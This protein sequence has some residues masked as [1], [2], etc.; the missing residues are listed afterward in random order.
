MA[1]SKPTGTDPVYTPGTDP[2]YTPGTARGAKL[3]ALLVDEGTALVRNI[4]ED[5]VKNMNPPSLREQLEN[6]RGCL[7]DNAMFKRQGKKCKVNLNR[8]QRD[9]LYPPGCD[10]PD[11]AQGFDI[12]LLERLLND[13][14]WLELGR[15]APHADHRNSFRQFRNNNYG[16]ISSTDLSQGDF[17]RLWKELSEILVAL[18]GDKDKISE[19]YNRS[20][21]PELE[22]E[23]FD[24]LEKLYKDDMELKAIVLAQGE[25]LRKRQEDIL[26][27]LRNLPEKVRDAQSP[28]TDPRQREDSSSRAD[29]GLA[30][31][32]HDVI[33]CLKDLYATE[34]AHVR[35]LPWCEDLNLHLG[36]IYTSLQ[37]QRRDD[38]G[39]F[40]GTN[41]IVSL[42]DIYNTGEGEDSQG[43]VRSCVRKI[44]VEGDPGIGKSCSC[45]K[46]AY[47]WSCG[48]LGRFKFVFFLEMRH[49]AGKVK[50][51]IFEQLLPKDT[52]MTADQLWSYIKENQEDVLFILDGLDELS[53]AARKV[54]DVVD[55]IQGK[56]LR[57]CHVLV[58]SR[59]YHSVEDL[60]KCHK[61]YKIAGYSW[62]N[63]EEFI[64]KYFCQSPGSASKLVEQ[65]QS[66][67]SLSEIVANPLNNVLIC[68]AWEDNNKHFP[69]SEAEL[70][71]MI[72]SL[73]AKRF[74]TKKNLPIK[75]GKFPPNIQD[76]LRGLGKLSWEGL[77][78]EELQFDIDEITKK[79]GATADNM[80]NMGLLTRDHSFSRIKRTCNCAFLHKTFQ[81]Y[82]A[83]RYM[84]GLVTEGSSREEGMRCLRS[85]FGLKKTSDIA[86]K[87]I[88]PISF[89]P[90]LFGLTNAPGI[91][92]ELVLKCRRKYREIQNWLLLILGGN[93]DP[94][95]DMFADQ[96][97]KATTDEDRDILSFVCIMWLGKTT[98]AGAEMAAI[99]A[100]YLS[101]HVHV[102]NN[103]GDLSDHYDRHINWFVGLTHL[104]TYQKKLAASNNPKFAQNL[105]INCSYI[106]AGS[107]D[108]DK[109]DLFD[110]AFLHYDNVRSVTLLETGG[111]SSAFYHTFSPLRTF[112]PRCGTESVSIDVNGTFYLSLLSSLEQLSKAPRVEH[113]RITVRGD[114][115]GI[116][117]PDIDFSEYDRL[118]AQMIRRQSCLKSIRLE[119]CEWNRE[120]PETRGLGNLTETLQSISEH[121]RLQDV[122]FKLPRNDTLVITANTS[123][124]EVVIVNNVKMVKYKRHETFNVE[125]MV[126]NLTEC[127]KKNKVLKTLRL[128]WKIGRAR[129]STS[130]IYY[131]VCS[132]KSFSD[133]CLAIQENRTLKS[134]VVERMISHHHVKRKAKMIAKLVR[135][136]PSNYEELSVTMARRSPGK[137]QTFRHFFLGQQ[138]DST[139]EETGWSSP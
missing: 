116:D 3:A 28:G 117:G 104:L 101:K 69:S 127:L 26:E 32:A 13:L 1:L 92:R 135:N 111:G 25:R 132:R 31:A 43:K 15:D 128:R 109:L 94:L 134:L 57:N 133:L 122:E 11:T 82:M 80:L 56:V 23:Y 138:S 66:N 35:P 27:E 58:T 7:Y 10:V 108:Q 81:E 5:E 106:N 18:G 114:M 131:G 119:I 99:V 95:F 89:L 63:S 91:D 88:F 83:A 62:K 130:R 71:E 120:D 136:K 45:Q 49:L 47:D 59:P 139:D 60:E 113:I 112:I 17:D 61:F 33:A 34:Y 41:T 6:H 123:F 37:L 100:P 8:C 107:S 65:L 55:L 86:G 90:S 79:Y 19:R 2:V 39:H 50:D 125:P 84:S 29:T 64:H 53:Q 70:Y 14:V 121:K 97:N 96:L 75:G 4:F 24:L 21:D 68:V 73:I 40:Q 22:A 42:S 20:I 76:A 38:K 48:K 103:L 98:C 87:P 16:H 115:K 77:E 9:T 102:T 72:V 124:E 118:L 67:R 78:L 30:D 36:E 54:T 74:C 46:L 51:A 110:K 105:T 93:A 52:D 129:N 12:S 44:R 137:F 85:L 126:H